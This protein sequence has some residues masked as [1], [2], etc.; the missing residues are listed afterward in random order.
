M[1]ELI[2]DAL[3]ENVDKVMD[4]I[5]SQI[6]GYDISPKTKMA[7]ELSVDEL[8]V[9]IA[10]YAYNP[11]PGKATIRVEMDKDA[12]ILQITFSDKG[13]PYNPLE[14]RDPDI[15]LSAEER[16][17]GGLGIFLAK[18]KMDEISYE[19][20]DGQNLLTIKKK[21]VGLPVQK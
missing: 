10:S 2:I 6:A 17:I 3:P 1:K 19:Y 8:F 21:L 18:K 4:F 11:E 12:P 7:I 9:N 13:V 16:N 20:K 5:F 14:K 15:T